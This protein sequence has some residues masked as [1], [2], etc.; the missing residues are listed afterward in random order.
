[1]TTE[2][3]TRS[4]PPP[5]AFFTMFLVGLLTAAGVKAVRDYVVFLDQR[6]TARLTSPDRQVDAVFVQ[7]QIGITPSE[8]LYLVP[9]GDPVPSWD[10]LLKITGLKQPLN[11]AWSRSG[12]L[13]V[14]YSRGCVERFANYWHSDD[15]AGGHRYVELR[16]IPETELPCGGDTIAHARPVKPALQANRPVNHTIAQT[17]ALRRS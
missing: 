10:P 13:E 15:V 17:G 3:R 12:M 6:E 9:K 16:L 1:M 11:V 8:S 5:I 7:P 14:R 4:T 2:P